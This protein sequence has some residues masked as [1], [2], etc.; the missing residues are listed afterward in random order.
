MLQDD[1]LL[2]K[3]TLPARAAHLAWRFSNMIEPFLSPSEHKKAPMSYAHYLLNLFTEALKLKV[4]TVQAAGRYEAVFPMPGEKYR[5]TC[6]ETSHRA[7]RK[8]GEKVFGPNGGSQPLPEAEVWIGFL[9]ALYRYDIGN[10]E[11]TPIEQRVATSKNFI[12]REETKCKGA[13]KLRSAVIHT[14]N[15]EMNDVERGAFFYRY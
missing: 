2:T 14:E 1:E 8:P 9:P 10:F 15:F 12:K 6:M 3:I 5:A 7:F 13:Q 11:S 4:A